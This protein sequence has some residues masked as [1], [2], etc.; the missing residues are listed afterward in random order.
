MIG[1]ALRKWALK[2]AKRKCQACG[3]EDRTAIVR[4]YDDFGGSVWRN[5]SDERVYSGWI[6]LVGNDVTDMIPVE[7]P[8]YP[9]PAFN[10]GI[11]DLYPRKRHLNVRLTVIDN[12]YLGIQ[13]LCQTCAG[14]AKKRKELT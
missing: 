8:P 5:L 12:G 13:A 9:H 2:R 14:R 10:L 11:G 1:P 3:V 7:D 4:R 6:D